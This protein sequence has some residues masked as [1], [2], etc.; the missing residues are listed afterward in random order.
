MIG[1]GLMVKHICVKFGDPGCIGFWDTVW[2]NG[3]TPVTNPAP[4][5]PLT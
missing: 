2:I 3:Q 4:W 5:L 1:S